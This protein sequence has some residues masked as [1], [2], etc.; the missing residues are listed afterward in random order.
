MRHSAPRDGR[1]ALA[2]TGGT[3]SSH[4][5]TTS[6]DPTVGNATVPDGVQDESHPTNVGIQNLGA[7][8]TR[9]DHHNA[10]DTLNS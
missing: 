1:P 5:Q 3:F 2:M 6:S 9:P 4:S 8:D 7:F 10:V